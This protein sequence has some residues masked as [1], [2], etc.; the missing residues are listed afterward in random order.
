[1][2]RR[3]VVLG[4]PRAADEAEY[5]A[6]NRRS[7]AFHRG[8]VEPP[9]TRTA[10]AA[11][12]RRS[13]QPG[14]VAFLIRRRSDGAI[15]GTVQLSHVVRGRLRS[16]YLGFSI[17]TPYARQ[18]Y[19]REALELALRHAFSRL[20]LHRVEAN[21]QPT[22]AASRA[23]VRRL[24]F[25]REG[26]SPR[27]LKIAGRWRDHERWALLVDDWRARRPGPR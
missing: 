14:T 5:L 11:Y 4:P 22:N 2:T 26:Y 15:V 20:R 6:L 16:A 12:L 18:G 8:W 25:A 13:R 9:T 3:R 10:F 17:G 19:M 24:G 23:L 27:Y 21:V 1:M 7:R